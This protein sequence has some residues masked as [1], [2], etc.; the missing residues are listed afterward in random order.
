MYESEHVY[1]DTRKCFAKGPNCGCS[2]LTS[3]Y[4]HDGECPFCK[5][6]RDMT[7][8]KLYPAGRMYTKP[9]TGLNTG[10]FVGF[11]KR[12]GGVKKNEGLYDNDDGSGGKYHR[13]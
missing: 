7:D 9:W 12:S 5:P 4:K 13:V 10:E 3:V 8:G 11:R 6:R 2:L 1:C